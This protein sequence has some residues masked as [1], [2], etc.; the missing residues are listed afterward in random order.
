MCI[1][2][3][4]CN[5]VGTGLTELVR[6]LALIPATH[7]LANVVNG[8]PSGKGWDARLRSSRSSLEI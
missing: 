8:F 3:W 6:G 1:W 2:G 4:R 5:S 7:K